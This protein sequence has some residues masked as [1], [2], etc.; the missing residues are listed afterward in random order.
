MAG[1]AHNNLI[2]DFSANLI[3]AGIP[4]Q[5]LY[6]TINNAVAAPVTAT[7]GLKPDQAGRIDTKIDDGVPDTGLVRGFGAV[8]VVANANNCGSVTAAGVPGVYATD[9]AVASCGL[10]IHVQN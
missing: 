6:L 5:G 3:G 1:S 4:E 2:G 9:T 10:H 8:G 7:A